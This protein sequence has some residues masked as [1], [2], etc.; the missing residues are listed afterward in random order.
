MSQATT[1][2]EQQAIQFGE[3]LVR[4]EIVCNSLWAF[5]SKDIRAASV[6]AEAKSLAV[7]FTE[8]VQRLMRQNEA[9]LTSAI[10]QKGK[11]DHEAQAALDVTRED[12]ARLAELITDVVKG[13]QS[14][15]RSPVRSDRAALHQA[16]SAY[17]AALRTHMD[18]SRKIVFD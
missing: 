12:H 17:S 15:L 9:I 5:V 7:F 18:W 6:T 3:N 1:A 16:I 4:L 11:G 2:T 10:R 14:F 13:L 8:E